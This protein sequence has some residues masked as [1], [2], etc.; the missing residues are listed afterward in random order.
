MAGGD[1]G[2]WRLPQTARELIIMC[3]CPGCG[4]IGRRRSP[5]QNRLEITGLGEL[6]NASNRLWLADGFRYFQMTMMYVVAKA[7]LVNWA[8]LRRNPEFLLSVGHAAE[9]PFDTYSS[10]SAHRS[11]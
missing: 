7:C 11:R 9:R 5:L 3:W 1:D 6:C 4:V 2:E 8:E 10:S